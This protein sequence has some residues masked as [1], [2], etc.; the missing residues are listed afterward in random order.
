MSDAK[1]QPS[2]VASA[3][4]C[5]V[6]AVA[7]L[8]VSL[9]G[10]SGYAAALT[11]S[12]APAT[13][14]AGGSQVFTASGGSPPY[15]WSLTTDGSGS[16]ATITPT[17]GAYTAGATAGTDV[18]TATDAVGNTGTATITVTVPKV[19]IG[20]ACVASDSCP[21]G[22]TCVDGVCCNSSCDGQCQAC[23]TAGNVGTCVTITV[24]PSGRG[25]PAR[26]RTR[27]TFARRRSATGRAPPPVPALLERR[28]RAASRRASTKWGRRV[29]SVK[30]T[31]DA[32]RSSPGRAHRMPASRTVAPRRAPTR[33]SAALATTATS[34]LESASRPRPCPSMP[35]RTP[36]HPR[37]PRPR[38]GVRW[39]SRR[40][41]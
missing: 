28:P 23:N 4:R 11:I 9:I 7:F 41:A 40:E 19:P 20:A 30:V 22:S 13:V 10:R 36:P 3:L 18:V 16:A 38:A 35:E 31:V 2:R 15:G 14:T 21:T 34:R 26:S 12:P 1:G 32:R 29:R 24:C 6:A 27:T 5:L 37:H 33:P 17:G 25:H 39:C 8:V